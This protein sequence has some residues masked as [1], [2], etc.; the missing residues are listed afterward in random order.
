[1]HGLVSHR[2]T[3]FPSLALLS[4]T[5]FAEVRIVG[6][7]GRVLVFL[8]NAAGCL[9]VC[10]GQLPVSTHVFENLEC[11]LVCACCMCMHIPLHVCV[12]KIIDLLS[13]WWSKQLL[14]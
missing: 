13:A 7:Y 10:L 3:P 9:T 6:H 4:V 12:L 11:A 14:I 1:M 5:A 2:I 8:F